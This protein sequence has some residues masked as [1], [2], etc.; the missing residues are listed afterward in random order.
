MVALTATRPA[1]PRQDSLWPPNQQLRERLRR[2]TADGAPRGDPKPPG[3]TDRMIVAVAPQSMTAA[4][5]PNRLCDR[6]VSEPKMRPHSIAARRVRYGEI[7]S[8]ALCRPD[9]DEM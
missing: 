4:M 3:N 8:A 1:L 6:P 9:L 2:S 7:Q 5:R